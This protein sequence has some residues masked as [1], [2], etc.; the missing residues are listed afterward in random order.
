MEAMLEHNGLKEFIDK[1][2]TKP[3]TSDAQN[4]AEW[5]N[6]VAKVRQIILEGVRDHIVSSAHGKETLYD[7]WKTLSDLC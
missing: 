1:E 3:T 2:I 5:K 6:C 7:M 4:L